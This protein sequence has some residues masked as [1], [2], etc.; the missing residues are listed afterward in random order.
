[1]HT[2]KNEAVATDKVVDALKAAGIGISDD[3]SNLR[4]TVGIN[5]T[6]VEW[7]EPYVPEP[8]PESEESEK[9]E[10]E[11]APKADA[12][13]KSDSKPDAKAKADDKSAK[14][15]AKSKTGQASE[16]PAKTDKK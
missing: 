3:W 8:A 12:K 14:K 4:I 11:A 2:R 5:A 6:G 13:A 15:P 1:M 16:E 9:P 7:S 10:K